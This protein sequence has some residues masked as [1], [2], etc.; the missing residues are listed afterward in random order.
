MSSPWAKIATPEP[1]SLQDIMS[2]EVAKELQVKED[3]KYAETIKAN[4]RKQERDIDLD[5]SQ[6]ILDS[7]DHENTDEL[8]SD[9]LIARML[10]KQ[11]D[12]EYDDM[13]KRTEDKFNG[14]SKVSISFSNYRRVPQ[15]SDFQSES[16]EE[17]VE[18]IRDRKDWDR[19]DTVQREFRTIPPCGYI[20]KDGNMITKHDITLSGRRNACKFMSFP[21]EF[22]TGDGAGF[23]LKLSNKVFNSL[24]LYSKHEQN[25]KHKFHDKKE[26][27][28]T[29]E[30]GVD[31]STRLLLYK[32]IN[33]QLLER[34]NGVISIGKEAVILH[35][36][37]D[38]SYPDAVL[39]KECV[40][41]VFKTTLSEFKQRE[42][43][44]RDDYRFKD[45][46]G[47]QSI[48]KTI[49]LWAEKEMHN[50]FR[51][52]KAGIPCPEVV[53]LKK[54]M[55]IMSFI[56]ED[57]NPAPKL[58]D[59]VLTAD[60]VELAYDQVIEAMK[61]LYTKAR[62]I[63]ADLSE[64]NILWHN[65]QCYFID[66]SQST[67]PSHMDAFHFLKRDCENII[68]FFS[69]KGVHNIKKPHELFKEITD[70]E[71]K[72]KLA[73]EALNNS[74]KMKPHLVGKPGM[75]PHDSFETA[76]HKLK[77]GQVPVAASVTNEAETVGLVDPLPA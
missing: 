66:V 3:K 67:E 55:L 49:H 21:P 39:P 9:A 74:F 14:T 37:T 28:A 7:I 71:F 64:Y 44:I 30:F 45:R 25:R 40:V 56:G 22:H 26:D 17:E 29:A 68:N 11:Y 52:Q 27:H 46:L 42:K 53:A 20:M 23:D 48:R 2:E 76:W 61:T 6:E 69:R 43:Y 16:E 38:P 19:F 70:C 8:D 59:A 35:A 12:Q 58:K 65:K 51:L 4:I 24:K 10:Q 33:N 13:L 60:E 75:E 5:I 62:L 32:M 15:H 47:K 18:D 36:D 77:T 1:T 72:D 50:L 63:H 73:A 34:V 54:H 41:K 57:H 31:E